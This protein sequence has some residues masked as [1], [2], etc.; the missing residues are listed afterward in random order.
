MPTD[1]T[2]PTVELVIAR[3]R[4][5]LSWLQAVGLPATVY[6]KSGQPAAH[7]LPNVG[8]ESHTYL[9]HILGRWPEF[10][11]YTVFLQGHPFPHLALGTTPG[12]LGQTILELATRG[13]P[14]KGLADYAIRCDGLGRPHHLHDP[15]QR[16]K[17]AGWGRD[18]P[19]AQVYAAL[20]A[21]EVPQS[22]HCRAPAGLLLVSRQR[23]LLRPRELYARAMALV[24]ADP[25]DA[26]NTGH[27]LERLW[28]LVFNGYAALNKANY[29]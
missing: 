24:L 18:I 25:E 28:Y 14:F 26:A 20:F 27:A 13:V 1:S 5:D 3:Y 10:P 2:S 12:A 4:E 7:P 22:F 9:H 8:R 11:D 21:G 6:D 19:V 17:W 15:A 29:A 16:G 23:L